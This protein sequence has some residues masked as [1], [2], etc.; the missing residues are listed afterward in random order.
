MSHEDKRDI[1][2]EIRVWYL[3][4]RDAGFGRFASIGFCYCLL[5]A[6]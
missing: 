1:A 6:P 2:I 5:I 4:F 3:S